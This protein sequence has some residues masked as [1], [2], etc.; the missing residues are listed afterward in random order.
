MLVY[1]Y[2]MM[3]VINKKMAWLF[4]RPSDLQM[5]F[6]NFIK[7][8]ILNST[9]K[10]LNQFSGKAMLMTF[11]FY[12]NRMNASRIFVIISI[13][14]IQT[15]LFFMN[16]KDMESRHFFIIFLEKGK[17]VGTVFIKPTFSSA[18]THFESFLSIVCKFVIIYT[19]AYL[20]FI[21]CYDWTK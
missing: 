7:S 8:N 13:L 2:L 5:I 10:N 6:C 21:I 3:F 16:E 18:Y 19:L 9:Q 20:C 1:S 17:F 4:D 15:C 14:V 12:S 11:L